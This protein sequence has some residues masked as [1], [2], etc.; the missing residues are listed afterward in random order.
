MSESPGDEGLCKEEIGLWDQ[1]W[2]AGP[3]ARCLLDTE[4]KDSDGKRARE[5]G[6][7]K[8]RTFSPSQRAW[9]SMKNQQYPE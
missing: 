8:E 6:T 3:G 2:A 1:L 5:E 9:V 4:R 7:R